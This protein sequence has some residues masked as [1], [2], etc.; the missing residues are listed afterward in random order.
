MS[1]KQH[2][3]NAGNVEI[4]KKCKRRFYFSTSIRKNPYRY[5]RYCRADLWDELVKISQEGKK[6]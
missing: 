5:C 4:C 1:D 3:E 6:K 2:A